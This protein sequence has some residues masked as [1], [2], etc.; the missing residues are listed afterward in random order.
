[1]PHNSVGLTT[2]HLRIPHTQ[3]GHG[4]CDDGT[5]LC[6]PGWEGDTCLYRTCPNRCSAR[7]ACLPSSLCACFD[8]W[9]GSDCSLPAPTGGVAARVLDPHFPLLEDQ[10]AVASPPPA[11]RVERASAVIAARS[12][13]R[14][15]HK[16]GV[17]ATA[18]V[19]EEHSM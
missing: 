5:C 4:K 14:E 17:E 1:M 15:L 16:P 11:S 9:Q 3:P 6:L 12:R 13:W 2:P 19:L 10:L 8:G 7:G 18:G